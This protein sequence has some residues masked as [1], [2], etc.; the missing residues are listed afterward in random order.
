MH[1]R[2]KRSG[3]GWRAQDEARLSRTRTSGSARIFTGPASRTPRFR[4]QAIVLSDPA[5]TGQVAVTPEY[6]Q[7][8]TSLGDGHDYPPIEMKGPVRT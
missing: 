6:W 3:G 1:S 7:A 5:L 4:R 2:P 8:V